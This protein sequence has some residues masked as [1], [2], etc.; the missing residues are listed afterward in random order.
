MTLLGPFQVVRS[1][2][3]ASQ[4]FDGV[5]EAGPE[6]DV[7]HGVVEP[8][9]GDA[10]VGLVGGHVVYTVVPAGQDQVVA[11]QE[12]D[13]GR[14]AK[15]GVGPLVDLVGQSHKDGQEQE[16]AV[17]GIVPLHVR[18]RAGQQDVGLRHQ[19]DQGHH[20]VV[21]IRLDQVVP[22][23][24]CRVYVVLPKRSDESLAKNR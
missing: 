24:G 16:E 21:A 1:G 9:R 2:G 23:D 22:C 13:P 10:E 8:A 17:P 3:D 20:A 19:A 6:A 11:L 5:L 12:L 14:Q 4:L 7:L 15:V 18:I